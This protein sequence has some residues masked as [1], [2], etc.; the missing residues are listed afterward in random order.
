[1]KI[2]A[3][4]WNIGKRQEP[5]HQLLDMDADVAL[6]QECGNIPPDVRPHIEVPDY[7]PWEPWKKGWYDRYCMVARL[8]DRMKVDWFKP[9]T[10]RHSGWLE[11]NEFV[12]SDIGTIA[13][14]RVTPIEGGDG[15]I[16]VSMYARWTGAQPSVAYGGYIYYDRSAH[17]II[18]DL[19][20]FIDGPDPSKHRIL[21]AGD[22]NMIYGVSEKSRLDSPDR[23]R[24]VTDRMSVTGLE[25]LGPQYP[26]GRK[27]NP[28]SPDVPPDSR[29]VPTYHTTRQS[30]ATA[31]NQLDYA[32]ASR[33]FH[34]SVQVSA[35]NSVEEWG[36]SD[37]CRLMVEIQF[38]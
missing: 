19:S 1:M 13:A 36:A 25:F 34:E 6:L 16:A 31:R 35:L 7:A 9:V 23:V 5:W 22:L 26:N 15:F 29:N 12:V 10:P 8:S 18:S 24:T 21:A 28:P 27:A 14:A 37:H 17:R 30:P 20:G 3:V 32:F 4:S 11:E 2:R 38:A 33:G